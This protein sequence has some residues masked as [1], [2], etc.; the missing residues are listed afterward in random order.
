M[1]ETLAG[2]QERGAAH[3]NCAQS[4]LYFS[5]RS[6]GHDP[7]SIVAARYLGGG[8]VRLGH[9]CGV[10]SGAALALGFRDMNAE[11]G[12]EVDAVAVTAQM[13]SIVHDFEEEFGATDCRTLTGHD[14]TTRD[15]Y[16][17]FAASDARPRCARYV[18]WAC[19]RVG[20]I[21]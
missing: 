11:E 3:R 12:E 14:L 9:L 7:G 18:E 10:L 4:V 8:M 17:A 6:L 21:I 16:R 1:A 5:L 13:Q 20:E 2:F 15:G 19:D